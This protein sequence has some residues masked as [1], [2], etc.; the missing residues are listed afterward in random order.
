MP[1]CEDANEST[2]ARVAVYRFHN[3]ADIQAGSKEAKCFAELD[4]FIS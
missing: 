3:V 4:L 1:F 2:V